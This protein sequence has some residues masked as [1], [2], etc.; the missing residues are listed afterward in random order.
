MLRCNKHKLPKHNLILSSLFNFLI[1]ANLANPSQSCSVD[2][3]A[4][5]LIFITDKNLSNLL[6]SIDLMS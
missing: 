6:Y 3:T 4:I 2:I 1:I 5:P